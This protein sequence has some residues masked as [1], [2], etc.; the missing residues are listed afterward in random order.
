[1]SVPT[2]PSDKVTPLRDPKRS[3]S[4][5]DAKDNKRS[6]TIMSAA[7]DIDRLPADLVLPALTVI[8]DPAIEKRVFTHSSMAAASK[9]SVRFME[10]KEAWRITRRWSGSETVS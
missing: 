8:V 1:M 6:D 7:V 4:P 9:S 3:G 2:P 10:E 5:L